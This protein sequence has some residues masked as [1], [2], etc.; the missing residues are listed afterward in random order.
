MPLLGQ[1]YGPLI[2]LHLFYSNEYITLNEKLPELIQKKTKLF[3][4]WSPLK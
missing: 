3:V 2:D 4:I 1:I